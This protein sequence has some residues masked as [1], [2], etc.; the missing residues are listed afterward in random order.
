MAPIIATYYQL[1]NLGTFKEFQDLL[2][3]TDYSIYHYSFICPQLNNS[4]YCYVSLRIQLNINH[5]F[6]HS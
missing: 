3:N 1:F 5:L 6:T 4:K 2:F